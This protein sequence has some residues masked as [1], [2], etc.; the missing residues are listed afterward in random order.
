[1]PLTLPALSKVLVVG[2]LAGSLGMTT[3]CSGGADDSKACAS[4]QQ[5]IQQLSQTA[6]SQISNPTAMA[7]TYHDKANSIR[8]TANGA[9]GSVRTAGLEVATAID[10]LGTDV[11]NLTSST[12]TVPQMPNTSALTNAGIAL[13]KACT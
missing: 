13:K 5:D 6:M 9:S 12:S 7:Q 2:V 8:A 11:G 1:M 4:M 3:A 10:G